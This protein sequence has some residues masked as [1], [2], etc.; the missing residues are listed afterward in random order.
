MKVEHQGYSARTCIPRRH[1]KNL[2][3]LDASHS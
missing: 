2:G 1:M 3:A